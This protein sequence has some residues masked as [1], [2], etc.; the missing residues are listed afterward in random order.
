MRASLL[1]LALPLVGML[2]AAAA[3]GAAQGLAPT[4]TLRVVFLG[5]NPV[6]ARV[7]EK[8]GAITGP[9]ADLVQEM[10]RR[11]RLEYTLIPSPN[12]AGVIEQVRAG[13][14][15]V[16]VL[17][18]EAARATQ[19]DFAGPFAVMLSG[20]LVRTPSP[21]RTIADADR[22]GQTIGA[23]RGQTQEIYLSANLKQARLRIF[24]TQPAPA[25]VQRMLVDGELHAFGLNRQRAEDAVASSSGALRAVPGSF[26]DVEQ[27]FVVRKGETAKAR[28]IDR[29]VAELRDS[30]FVRASIERAKLVGVAVAPSRAR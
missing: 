5:T 18:Y 10:A 15:D 26:V 3:P 23:V 2:A 29:L 16:G 1:P 21:I 25:E 4:G 12:A 13:T 20:Y 27:S 6:H 24:D 30:G 17:A 19:V 14:A 8:T 11:L 28:E 9:V 22:A 7:D